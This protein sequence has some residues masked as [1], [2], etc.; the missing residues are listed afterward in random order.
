MRDWW[1]PF[2]IALHLD[3]V[4]TWLGMVLCIDLAPLLCFRASISRG[5][6][7]SFV[8]SGL[9]V[10]GAGLVAGGLGG[11]VSGGPGAGLIKVGAAF[12]VLA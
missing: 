4:A 11:V 8:R 1:R 9:L 7:F 5:L 10:S 3:K 2:F 6:L 12:E